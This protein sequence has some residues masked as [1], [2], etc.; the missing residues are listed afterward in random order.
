MNRDFGRS[1]D[2]Q[3]QG[4]NLI[5][6]VD[7][8]NPL[9][10]LAIALVW[11]IAAT[12]VFDLRFLAA[13]VAILV[14]VIRLAGRATAKSMAKAFLL[15]GL[16]GIGLLQAQ[17][18]FPASNEWYARSLANDSVA[19]VD[20]MTAGLTV[21]LRAMAY[22][23]ISF[24]F[25]VTTNPAELLR[26]CM[27]HLRLPPFVGFSILSAIQFIPSLA[28][29]L[30]LLRRAHS[31]RH[32]NRRLRRFGIYIGLTI[33]LLASAVRRASRAAVSMEARGLTR[34]MTRTN[35]RSSR[36]HWSDGAFAVLS[37]FVLAALLQM[38]S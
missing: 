33:A 23:A 5:P 9:T 17:L 20:P 37:M 13:M 18:L 24:A 34:N 12:I 7:M 32:T 8:I 11:F 15:F 28:D 21:F 38:R 30:S 3:G 6:I 25:V 19:G 35:L 16:A 36:L 29:D 26:A 10:K 22:G 2:G 1:I 14:V 27:Q 4:A 31:M